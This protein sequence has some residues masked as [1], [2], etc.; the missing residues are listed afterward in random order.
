MK[1]NMENMDKR[2]KKIMSRIFDINLTKINENFHIDNTPNWDSLNHFKLISAVEN[3]FGITIDSGHIA[4][5]LDFKSI[6]EIVSSHLNLKK[7]TS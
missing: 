6:S 1:K 2:L 4:K 7:N 3:E 5:M